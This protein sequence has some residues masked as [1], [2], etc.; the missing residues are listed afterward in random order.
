[1]THYDPWRRTRIPRSRSVRI[2][3]RRRGEKA[4]L[5]IP[6]PGPRPS[7]QPVAPPAASPPAAP[8]TPPPNWQER[9][10]QL[11][12]EAAKTRER[13]QKRYAEETSHQVQEVIRDLLP[14]VDNLQAALAH[15]DAG[16]P[17]QL[18]QGVELT[19]RLFLSTLSRHG[20]TPIAALG[21]PFDPRYHEAIGEIADADV[22]PG[23]V[24]RV[25]QEGYLHHDRLLRPAR[26]LIAS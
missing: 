10:Q 17:E 21:Q 20:V 2:P 6:H 18:R 24:A 4:Q 26:V 22:A 9:Y 16:D 3:V 5:P 19:L 13:L 11:Q 14:V 7:D 1:M 8:Q 25:L 12:T 23:H 15:S